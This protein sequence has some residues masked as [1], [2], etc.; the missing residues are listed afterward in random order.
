MNIFN[1]N[2]VLKD[3]ASLRAQDQGNG[4][5]LY[6]G[7]HGF[8]DPE[9]DAKNIKTLFCNLRW[10]HMAGHFVWVYFATLVST[11]TFIKSITPYI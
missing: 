10:K 5:I 2:A 3:M 4:P 11:F 8:N 1:M 7:I 9:N 6:F